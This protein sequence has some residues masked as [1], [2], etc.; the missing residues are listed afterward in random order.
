MS[1]SAVLGTIGDPG[2]QARAV[3]CEECATYKLGDNLEDVWDHNTH[4]VTVIEGVE[5]IETFASKQRH[6]KRDGTD[7]GD[8]ENR[9][10]VEYPHRTKRPCSR[11][12]P[13]RYRLYETGHFRADHKAAGA[14]S[15][16]RHYHGMGKDP[17]MEK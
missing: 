1:G 10:Y 11:C 3:E 5:L 15:L 14:C 12:L 13:E 16:C 2:E 9:E 4:W 7:D 8:T 6:R 17:R